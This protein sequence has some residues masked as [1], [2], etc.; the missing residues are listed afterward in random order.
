MSRSP[1]PQQEEQRLQTLRSLGL[2]D[3]AP[4]E[5]FNRIIRMAARLFDVPMVLFSLVDRDRLWFKAR[6]G[7]EQDDYP[8]AES[9]C[10]HTI[11]TDDVLVVVDPATDERFA[12]YPA[13][14]GPSAIRFYAGVP[15]KAPDRAT[16]GTLCL[17]D[18]RPRRLDAAQR[19]LLVDLAATIESEVAAGALRRALKIQRDN[20]AAMAG[21][22]NKLPEGFMLLDAEGIVLSANPAAERL[23]G[24]GPGQLAQRTAGELLSSEIGPLLQQVREGTG[25][26]LQATARCLDGETFAVEFSAS[27]VY[28][29]DNERY[30]VIVR[31]V[32]QRRENERRDRATDARR[33]H[34]F[35]TA[36]HELRTPMASVVGFTEL[37]LKRDFS[38]ESMREFIGIIHVQ[39][40]RLVTLINEM[41]DLARIESGGS[42]AFEIG[43]HDAAA[44]ITTTIAGLDGLVEE[45]TIHVDVAPGLPPVLADAAKLQ[46]ALLNLIGN[47]VKYSAEDSPIDVGANAAL[48]DDRPAVAF[49]VRDRGVG[50]TP[51]QQARAF[52]AFYRSGEKRDVVGS[53][54]GLTIVQEIVK[55]H[56]GAVQLE[57]APGAGTTV[58]LLLPAATR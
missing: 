40:T 12:G 30:V 22:L 21:L 26:Q 27:M 13:L 14:S 43:P 36:T 3:T 5:R 11:M 33:R 34:Y 15:I 4:E 49:H 9:I 20:E 35:V 8:R 51:D 47:A 54:L 7:F 48:H 10:A 46:Q 19:A 31:D 39:A 57:S 23:F 32:T 6:L 25:S 42:Q 56:G 38:P 52:D 55:L 2:L 1:L 24:A 16:I 53:G 58:T 50:M 29:S 17:A 44:V 45:S 28:M 41:L 37:L 18:M